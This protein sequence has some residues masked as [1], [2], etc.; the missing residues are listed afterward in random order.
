M[1]NYL[2]N[3]FSV[4]IPVYNRE[5]TIKRAILSL[6]T[7]SY[8]LEN[9]QLIVVDDGSTDKTPEVLAKIFSS[10]ILAFAKDSILITFP[11][12]QG[13]LAAR[14]VGMGKASN[15]WIC[16]LDSDDEYAS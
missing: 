8:P 11:T 12:N 9:I 13:R 7:Q 15:D 1:K 10:K 16:W 14:N 4:I 6:L 5:S 2:M 3:K